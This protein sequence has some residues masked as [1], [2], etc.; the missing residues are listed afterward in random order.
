MQGMFKANGGCGFVKKPDFL[1]NSGEVFDP[2]VKLPLKTTLK[3]S[4]LLP[5]HLTRFN[6]CRPFPQVPMKSLLVYFALSLVNNCNFLV[7][8]K[9]KVYMGEGWYYDF[10][11]THFDAYSPPDFYVRVSRYNFLSL[12]L[13]STFSH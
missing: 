4:A 12:N 6:F 8:V 2:K 11:H 9:V 10:H 7:A 5:W 3:V 1:L 13:S